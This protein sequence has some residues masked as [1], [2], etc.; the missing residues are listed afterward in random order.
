ML[1]PGTGSVESTNSAEG[2]MSPIDP[3]DAG[4]MLDGPP[5]ESFDEEFLNLIAGIP[6]VVADNSDLPAV[7]NAPAVATTTFDASHLAIAIP[8]Q[9]SGEVANQ[10]A[11]HPMSNSAI[12]ETI[13]GRSPQLIDDNQPIGTASPV[14]VVDADGKSTLAQPPLQ[15]TPADE[16][17]ETTSDSEGDVASLK[18]QAGAT[19]QTR[20]ESES[21]QQHDGDDNWT[22][23]SH[24]IGHESNLKTS[25]LP[26]PRQPL[27]TAID[28]TVE[29]RPT[30][31]SNAAGMLTETPAVGGA[32]FQTT[33]A[34]T[35]MTT[36]PTSIDPPA[37]LAQQIANEAV[38]HAEL[39]KHQGQQ[40][41]TMRLDPPELGELEIEME[42][43]VDGISLRV[44]AVEATTMS[45]IQDSLD[46]LSR[47]PNQQDSVFQEMNIDVS[48]GNHSSPG[49]SHQK[50]THHNQSPL[51]SANDPGEA[52]Q[53]ETEEV[54]FVA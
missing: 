49:H 4:L 22:E 19:D 51:L 38:R 11:S 41:F 42:R 44:H 47:D 20:S 23:Q 27:Q 52:P 31:E 21:A 35:G 17:T 43:T 29:A 25:G 3:Q 10:L 2:G 12:S 34:D 8:T 48:T 32:S 45:M 9:Q 16:V 30:A 36:G 28:E 7:S 5:A 18:S 54:S 24:K 1:M 46:L 50:Q 15:E 33:Q 39:V 14:D 26:R 6:I 53:Q 37:D 40:R 13:V